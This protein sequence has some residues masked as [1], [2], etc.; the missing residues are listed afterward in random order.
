MGEYEQRR[1][2]DVQTGR[3]MRISA[4]GGLVG[5]VLLAL[6]GVAT[7]LG[8]S[9]AQWAVVNPLG[10]IAMV[11]L[12]V[13]LPALYLSERHWFGTLARV[14]FGVMAVGWIATAVTMTAFALG[15]EAGGLAFLVGWLVAMVGALVFGVSMLRTDAATVPRLGAWLL[16]AALPVGLPVSVAFTWY[17]LGQVDTPWNGPLVLYA[18]AWTVFCYHLRTRRTDALAAEAVPR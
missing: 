6:L 17:V 11:L 18:L 7:H 4:T 8:L 15:S 10:A 13:G 12:A 9:D 2:A 16:V 3:W 14:G 5:G 1:T